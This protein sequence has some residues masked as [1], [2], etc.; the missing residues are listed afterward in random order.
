MAVQPVPA[1]SSAY[2]TKSTATTDQV[3]NPNA[4]LGKNEFLQMLVT[5]LANQDPTNPVDDAAFTAELAQ[6]SSL[7]QMQSLNTSASAQTVSLQ[8]LNTNIVALMM[9]QNTTQAAG[10]IGKTV[11]IS[12]TAVDSS[13]ASIPGPDV[14]GPVSVVT[15]V[16]GQPKIIVN[17][18]T[19]GLASIKSISA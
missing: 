6:F 4:S 17:G 5:K 14:T 18:V 10:L 16:S 2:V 13:G 15:F 11:T 12:T 7:E 3:A 1:T 8:D 9:M 19:Y